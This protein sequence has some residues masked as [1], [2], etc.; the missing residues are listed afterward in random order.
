MQPHWSTYTPQIHHTLP[1]LYS[2]C[3]KQ[4]EHPMQ[5]FCALTEQSK[6]HKCRTHFYHPIESSLHVSSRSNNNNNNNNK[7]AKSMREGRKAC[8]FH[9]TSKLWKEAK[10]AW[11]TGDSKEIGQE[12][13][14]LGTWHVKEPLDGKVKRPRKKCLCTSP[15]LTNFFQF[16]TISVAE[17]HPYLHATRCEY[18]IQKT[19]LSVW[20]N[21]T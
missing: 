8:I 6:E 12:D 5:L 7:K 17:L 2:Q 21:S 20:D 1:K 16:L 19:K 11:N 3:S 4:R 9:Q 15:M 18:K 10:Q 14:L 13:Q